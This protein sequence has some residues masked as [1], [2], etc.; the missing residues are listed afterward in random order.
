MLGVGL[1][2]TPQASASNYDR[3]VL[4][5][6][7]NAAAGELDQLVAFDGSYTGRLSD[8]DPSLP[9]N[10][11]AVSTPADPALFDTDFAISITTPFVDQ[12]TNSV[13]LER[14]S[15]WQVPGFAQAGSSQKLL[16]PAD[17]QNLTVTATR[18]IGGTWDITANPPTCSSGDTGPTVRVFGSAPDLDPGN[19]GSSSASGGGTGE[20]IQQFAKSPSMTCDEAQPEGLNW[21][22]AP[23]GGWGESWAQ[24]PNDGRGGEVCVRTLFYNTATGK[25]DVR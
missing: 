22:D 3:L 23:S 5:Y 9:N 15:A 19:S 13:L 1:A 21:S 24:W 8:L 25:W 2:L 14:G 10:A 12:P 7:E 16:D 11:L 20:Y 6:G 18:C 4:V 17:T